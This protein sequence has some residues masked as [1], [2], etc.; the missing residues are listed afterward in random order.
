MDKNKSIDRK[1]LCVF[2]AVGKELGK[3]TFYVFRM[4]WLQDYFY[5]TYKGRR[6]PKNINSF[7][8]AIW[9]KDLEKHLD[10]WSLLEK[11]FGLNADLS[12]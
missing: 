3:D 6:H 4:G 11:T 5:E 2:V 8:C 9:K 1:I 7:H 12:I 10:K